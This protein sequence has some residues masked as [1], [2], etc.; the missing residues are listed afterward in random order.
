M[1][2]WENQPKKNPHCICNIQK[3]QEYNGNVYLQGDYNYYQ[4]GI[5]ISNAQAEDSG[6]WSCDL[7]EYNRGGARNTGAKV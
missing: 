1:L 4:C 2:K 3:I 7:E 6:E 5:E